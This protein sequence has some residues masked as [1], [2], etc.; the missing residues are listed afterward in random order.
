MVARHRSWCKQSAGEWFLDPG[1]PEVRSYLT[2]LV[3]EV[4]SKYDVD[5]IHLDYVRY[6]DDAR[7]FPDADSFG[8]GGRVLLLGPVGA[9]RTLR[10][11][12]QPFTTR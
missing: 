3:S 7:R 12:L 9:S 2:D 6:P 8:D 1:N 10:P 11:R 5:G 4:V